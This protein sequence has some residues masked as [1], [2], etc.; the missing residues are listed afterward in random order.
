MWYY[1]TLTRITKMKNTD[2]TKSWQGC[3][4]WDFHTELK[5]VK[6]KK[7][8]CGVTTLEIQLVVSTKPEYLAIPPSGIYDN[9]NTHIFTKRPAQENDSN[10]HW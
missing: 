5:A 4:T 7:K 10:D 3:R 1:N 6:K 8:K 2:N 9:R